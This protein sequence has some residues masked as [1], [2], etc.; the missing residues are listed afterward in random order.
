M[1][2]TAC[3]Q[4]IA[5]LLILILALGPVLTPGPWQVAFAQ[6]DVCS[7]PNDHPSTACSSPAG[8]GTRSLIDRPGDVDAYRVEIVEDRSQVQIDLTELPADYD[9]YLADAF[10][11]VYGQSVQDGTASEHLRLMVRQ[12][13]YYV[14]VQADPGREV[15]PDQPYLLQVAVTEAEGW[16]VSASASKPG[17]E[18]HFDDPSQGV[19][20]MGSRNPDL[21]TVE[22]VDGIYR[23]VNTDPTNRYWGPILPGIYDDSILSVRARLVG[24]VT[25]GAISLGCRRDI[26][27]GDPVFP[28]MYRLHVFPAARQ[29]ELLMWDGSVRAPLVARRSSASIQPRDAWNELRLDCLGDTI[30]AYANGQELARVVDS[31]HRRGALVIGVA[32]AGPRQ[33]ITE[34]HLDDVVVTVP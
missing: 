16:T 19:L 14:Y 5:S 33:L 6:G 25:G 24:D 23:I 4:S 8:A 28:K 27:S 17:L 10:G 12:G 18:D 13:T 11:G 21:F 20:P 2:V 32:G 34:A 15:H 1:T 29:F 3:R 9:L 22:Y 7:E 30:A 31:T 26:R